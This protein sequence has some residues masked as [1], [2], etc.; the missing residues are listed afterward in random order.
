MLK[1]KGIGILNFQLPSSPSRY[2]PSESFFTAKCFIFHDFSSAGLESANA[3]KS[4]ILKRAT[5]TSD[6]GHPRR[7]V[8]ITSIPDHE[9]ICNVQESSI[10]VIEKERKSQ[11]TRETVRIKQ[12]KK[13]V[14]RLGIEPRTTVYA[15][16]RSDH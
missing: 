2:V 4:A 14:S 5:N 1:L 3:A 13:S 10:I 9:H 15:P 8:H 11:N 6:A 12:R 7:Q 16:L